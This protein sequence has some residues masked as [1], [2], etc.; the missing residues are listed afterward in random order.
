MKLG[1][2]ENQRDVGWRPTR[3]DGG[4]SR[5]DGGSRVEFGG[6]RWN[7]GVLVSRRVRVG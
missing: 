6:L 2:G 7:K 4:K 1:N 3:L 5:E